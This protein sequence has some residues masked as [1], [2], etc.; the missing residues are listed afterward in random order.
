[1]LSYILMY[2]FSIYWR[3]VRLRHRNKVTKLL[4]LQLYFLPKNIQ[5]PDRKLQKKFEIAA[6]IMYKYRK[7]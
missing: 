5:S 7:I 3:L 2:F 4:Y 1:M 6:H